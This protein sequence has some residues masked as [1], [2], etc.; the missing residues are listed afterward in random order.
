MPR[1]LGRSD[2]ATHELP[3]QRG[4]GVL[5]GGGRRVGGPARAG[6]CARRRQQ[7]HR[8]Q[9]PLGPRGRPAVPE[10]HVGRRVPA[11]KADDQDSRTPYAD[12]RADSRTRRR[13]A[14]PAGHTGRRPEGHSVPHAD[15][16][17][18]GQVRRTDRRP[19][20]RRPHDRRAARGVQ[21][22]HG[23]HAAVDGRGHRRRRPE[24]VG[25]AV[26]AGVAR[27]SGAGRHQ[28]GGLLDRG[29]MRPS[30]RAHTCDERRLQP[31]AGPE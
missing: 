25:P 18:A 30:R 26:G 9:A 17:R 6:D 19:V 23:A 5:R 12:G 31:H 21:G 14:P 16:E 10:H 20:C 24:R 4:G 13:L 22:P 2:R 28:L 8:V 3:R 1:R 11:K 29:R 27:R 15:C 7:R